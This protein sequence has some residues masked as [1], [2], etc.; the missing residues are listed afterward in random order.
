MYLVDTNVIS[1][2]RKKLKAN[3]GIR[4]FFKKVI[5][6]ATPLFVS[7]VTVG[8]LRRGVELVRYR[9]DV[10]QA[11]QLD[12]WL[13]A[14]LGKYQDNILDINQDIAQLWGKLRV[15]HPE[16]AMDKQIA[17]T[18]LVYD[19][20]VVTRNHKDFIRTGVPVLNPFT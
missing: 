6:D 15:P 13:D 8:E 10:R 18:A 20:T 19:L 2:I 11:D 12:E 7:V 5:E 14:L 3:Q 16:N 4:A 1:E 17:A 9:G